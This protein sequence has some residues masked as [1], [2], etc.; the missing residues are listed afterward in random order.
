M[1]KTEGQLFSLRAYGTIGKIITYQGRRFFRHSHKKALPRNP[2]TIA[3]KIDRQHFATAV[4]LWQSL[5]P[6]EKKEYNLIGRQQN[7]I[8]GF[9]AFI[10]MYKNKA[11][12]WTK[13]SQGKF[14]TT[15]RF[16]GPD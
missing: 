1:A 14:G 10:S 8:P 7:N 11:K 2:R 6:A 4:S 3:Q 13:F 5:T 15:K 12:Y 9:N 16:G